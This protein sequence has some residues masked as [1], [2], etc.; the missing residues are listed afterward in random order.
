MATKL[1]QTKLGNML[2]FWTLHFLRNFLGKKSVEVKTIISL[3]Y[4]K[5]KLSITKSNKNLARDSC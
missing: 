5:D 2:L 3:L 1:Y 4:N